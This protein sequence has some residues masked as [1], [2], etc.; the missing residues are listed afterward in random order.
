MSGAGGK[1]GREKARPRKVDAPFFL[2]FFFILL[3]KKCVRPPQL[4]SSDQCTDL[5]TS[6]SLQC[7]ARASSS[8]EGA[9]ALVST[10]DVLVKHCRGR[11]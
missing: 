6:P 3:S 4:S 2:L 5:C 11:C 10:F 9:K 7:P 1:K 8:R